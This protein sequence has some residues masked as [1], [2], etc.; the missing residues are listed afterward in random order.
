VLAITLLGGIIGLVLAQ[1]LPKEK[2]FNVVMCAAL[3][4]AL[5]GVVL[6][7]STR[8]GG[9]LNKAFLKSNRVGTLN[10]KEDESMSTNS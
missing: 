5:L 6:A 8:K 3:I 4:G 1:F 9:L 7:E 10:D 2:E